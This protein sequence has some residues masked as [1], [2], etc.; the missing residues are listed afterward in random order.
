MTDF[1]ARIVRRE[2]L[3]RG[4]VRD[5]SGLP[6]NVRAQLPA[7]IEEAREWRQGQFGGLVRTRWRIR[8][9]VRERL[10]PFGAVDG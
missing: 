1:H 5:E 6:E 8:D 2:V 4:K 3:R 10:W 7:M 9:W